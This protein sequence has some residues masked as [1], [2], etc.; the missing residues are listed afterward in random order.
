MKSVDI[1]VLNGKLRECARLAASGETILVTDRDMAVAEL[2]PPK[3][4]RN[5]IL[6]EAVRFGVLTLPGPATSGPPPK[7]ETVATLEE[8]LGDLDECRRDR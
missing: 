4:T 6:A 3:D 7:P 1:K 5:P 2:G 8:I